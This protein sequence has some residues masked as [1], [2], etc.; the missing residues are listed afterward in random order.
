M[1]K[2]SLGSTF[3]IF[4]SRHIRP[5]VAGCHV[6]KMTVADHHPSLEVVGGA[7]DRFLHSLHTNLR[8]PYNP[9]PLI[10]WNRH[11]ETIFASFFRSIPQVRLRRECLRVKDGGS[12]ALDWVS[13]DHSRLPPHSP[14][15][16][17]LVKSDTITFQKILLLSINYLIQEASIFTFDFLIFWAAGFDWRKPG[18]ICKKYVN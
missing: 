3:S 5:P 17:L 9:F 15:L 8:L 6:T 10:A 11:V 13:G 18:F 16:I 2:L 14:V 1:A 12:V 7:R 4:H